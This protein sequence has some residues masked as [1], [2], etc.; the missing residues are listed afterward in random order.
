MSSNVCKILSTAAGLDDALVE[1]SERP[2]V[3]LKHSVW[4]GLSQRVIKG[5]LRDLEAWAQQIGCR[6]VIVQKRRNL[7]DAIADRLGVAHET[8]QMLIIRNGRVTWMPPTVASQQK[9]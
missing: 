8:P 9:H 7:S 1:S 6:I 4:C 5:A 3:L 2:V